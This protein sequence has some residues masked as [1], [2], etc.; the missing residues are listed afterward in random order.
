MTYKFAKTFVCANGKAYTDSAVLVLLKMNVHA[1][2]SI[3]KTQSFK[4]L[5][6][7]LIANKVNEETREVIEF[8]NRPAI[9]AY[10]DAVGAASV[11]ET[12]KYFPTNPVGLVIGENDIF[13]RSPRQKKG[14]NIQFH[15]NILGG[16]GG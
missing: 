9:S 16:N 6:H 13:V 15:C 2:F 14:T 4:A 3:I 8:N 12:P 1:E 5:D 7:V 10:A 11:E